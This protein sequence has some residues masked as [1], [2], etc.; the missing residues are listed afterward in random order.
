MEF[1]VASFQLEEEPD[2]TKG[3]I[4]LIPLFVLMD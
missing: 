1:N 2:R 3:K 4:Y